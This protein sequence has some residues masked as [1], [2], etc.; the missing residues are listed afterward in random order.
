M[1]WSTTPLSLCRSAL[2]TSFFVKRCAAPVGSSGSGAVLPT[3]T[4]ACAQKS[5]VHRQPAG[6]HVNQVSQCRSSGMTS[7]HE[8]LLPAY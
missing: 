7:C 1:T 3:I 8:L 6:Q 4:S 5:T 2:L